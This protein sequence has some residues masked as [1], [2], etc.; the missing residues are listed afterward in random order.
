MPFHR[1]Y[2]QLRVTAI[3]GKGFL[4]KLWLGGK[5]APGIGEGQEHIDYNICR[6]PSTEK[7]WGFYP[8]T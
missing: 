1:I 2:Y 5:S 8:A 7:G 4:L 6:S 3:K